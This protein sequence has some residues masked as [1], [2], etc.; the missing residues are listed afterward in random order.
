MFSALSFLLSMLAGY[1]DTAGFL[2]LHGLF[3]AHVTGNFVTIGASLVY[4]TTGALSKLLALPV[5]CVVIALV[6]A[7]GTALDKIGPG[8]TAAVRVLLGVMSALLL[9]AGALAIAL[10]PFSDA[11][12]GPALAT[13]MTLVAAMSV[14]N[15]VHRIY[16]AS[17]PPTTLMTGSTT[18]FVI[19][20]V[21]LMR[22][23]PEDKKGVVRQRE[24]RLGTSI[25]AFGIGCGGAAVLFHFGG[26]WCF[27]LPPVLGLLSIAVF[28]P[29]P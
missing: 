6:R 28:P 10:G 24:S 2:A 11:D 12:N 26:T 27:A 16:L 13:G 22:G 14:L 4:G 18:Q 19:D 17:L 3:T 15:A 25:L 20:V 29:V 9:A 5:F 21:D 1:V 8:G 23:V 7:A